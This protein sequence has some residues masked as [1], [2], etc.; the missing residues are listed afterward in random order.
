MLYDVV[1]AY[2]TNISSDMIF[3]SAYSP[4]VIQILHN[5]SCRRVL[6]NK[7]AQKMVLSLSV[8]G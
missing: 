3:S 2:P 1:G 8:S 6:R 7:V 4:E 5:S